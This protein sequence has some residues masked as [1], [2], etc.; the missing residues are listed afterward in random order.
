MGQFGKSH[1]VASCSWTE[2]VV[3]ALNYLLAASAKNINLLFLFIVLFNE[4]SS[5]AMILGANLNEG[6]HA[7]QFS[8]I[9]CRCVSKSYCGLLGQFYPQ[10]A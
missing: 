8:A 6:L 4:Y 1:T 5:L 9:S 10:S 3:P 2:G 7:L